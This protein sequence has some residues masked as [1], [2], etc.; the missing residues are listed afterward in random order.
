MRM[1][2]SYPFSEC[3]TYALSIGDPL[4][5]GPEITAKLLLD[6][7]VQQDLRQG[8]YRLVILGDTEK[9]WEWVHRL[10]PQTSDAYATLQHP[11]V[12]EALQWYTAQGER[13]GEKVWDALS[14]A[15][16]LIATGTCHGLVTGPISK[17]HLQE[18]GITHQGHTE[19]L[20]Y[21]TRQLGLAHTQPQQTSAVIQAEMLFVYENLRVLTLTRH[22]P[23]AEVERRITGAMLEKTVAIL[24]RFLSRHRSPF[25]SPHSVPRIALLGVNPH[26]GEVGGVVEHSVMRPFVAQYQRNRQPHEALLEGPLPADAVFRGLH[27]QTPAYDAY[28]ASYH[29]QGLIPVKLLGG[30]DCVN[31]TIGLPFVRTSVSHGTA[32]DI[33]GLGIASHRSLYTALQQ[34]HTFSMPITSYPK[35]MAGGVTSV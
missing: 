24:N 34:L 20:D 23:L 10:M 16:H 22:L 3:P 26:A 11:E 9:V 28:I 32:E 6:P 19:I 13:P 1:S 30:F 33:A 35:A 8:V 21:W 5:I 25:A 7:L 15:M 14:H 29:D 12:Q 4:G 17:R 2:G 27:A 31:V 18:V